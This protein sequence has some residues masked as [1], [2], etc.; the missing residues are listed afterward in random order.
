MLRRPSKR[1]EIPLSRPPDPE[2][3]LA[4]CLA[5][6]EGTRAAAFQQLGELLYRMLLRRVESDPRTEHLPA[7]CSQEAVVTIWRQLEAGRGPD[8]PASFIGWSARI[9]LN[10]LRD[11]KRRMDPRSEIRRTKRVALRD[12][13]RLDVVDDEGRSAA[14]RLAG[15]GAD[16]IDDSLAQSALRELMLGIQHLSVISDSSK[17]VLLQGYLGEVDDAEL[18]DMLGTSRSNVHVIRCRDLAKLRR[19]E[20]FMRRLARCRGGA[21][22]RAA[23]DD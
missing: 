1:L 17:E 22:E 9:A 10:K 19:D 20:E 7:D 12:Q 6:D 14:E 11:A 8:Q 5:E 18:A 21:P 13:V 16:E 15:Q 23:D 4:A 3:L 2:Q